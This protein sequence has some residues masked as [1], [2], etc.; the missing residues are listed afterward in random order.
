M[1]SFSLENKTALLSIADDKPENKF[2]IDNLK[3]VQEWKASVIV[4]IYK[5]LKNHK[6]R[7]APRFH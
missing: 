7:G 2:G 3:L 1:I 5:T 4:E 6:K